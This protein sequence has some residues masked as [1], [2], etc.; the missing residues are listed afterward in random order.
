MNLEKSTQRRAV[1]TWNK[2]K[3]QSIN[4]DRDQVSD[5]KKTD[6]DTMLRTIFLAMIGIE[7]YILWKF[8]LPIVI[9]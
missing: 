7:I 4:C 9:E 6:N 8:A 2:G 5:D 1:N 3:W